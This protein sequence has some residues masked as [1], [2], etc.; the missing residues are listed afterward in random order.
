MKMIPRVTNAVGI[1]SASRSRLA[2]A[3]TN[4]RTPARVMARCLDLMV[5]SKPVLSLSL[6]G[7]SRLGEDR[8]GR[9]DC[10]VL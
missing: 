10:L 2:A 8:P 7:Q 9:L 6:L 5:I 4:I 1:A 3:I